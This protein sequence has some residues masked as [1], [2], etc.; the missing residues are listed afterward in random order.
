MAPGWVGGVNRR[1]PN[2]DGRDPGDAELHGAGTSRWELG[3]QSAGGG[4]PGGGRV[5]AGGHSV[6]GADRPAAVPGRNGDGDAPPSPGE[7]ADPASEFP[8]E[9]APGPGDG[10]PEVPGEVA[11]TPVRRRLGAGGGPEAVPGGRVAA[12]AS[13]GRPGTARAMVSAQAVGGRT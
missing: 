7:G 1:R 11:R 9:R 10:L 13:G 8:A 4:R 2:A 6:R 3:G 12:G 5:G